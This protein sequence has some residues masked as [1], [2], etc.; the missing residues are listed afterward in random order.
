MIS[1]PFPS[2]HLATYLEV[3]L[4]AASSIPLKDVF[5]P[6][7]H[8]SDLI[9]CFRRNSNHFPPCCASTIPI[10]RNALFLA[11]PRQDDIS[12]GRPQGSDRD[13]K[14]DCVA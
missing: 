8:T 4:N 5:D 12:V 7:T 10:I 9:L 13:H 14:L 2:V 3:H 11:L 1:A 6:R